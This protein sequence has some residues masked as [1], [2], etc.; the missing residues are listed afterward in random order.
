MSA[1]QK[2][3]TKK[4]IV[5]KNCGTIFN[6]NFCSH[7]GQSAKTHRIDFKHLIH[8]FLHAITHMDV[9]YLH[10]IKDLAIRPGHFIRGYLQGK[11][12]KQGDPALM[13]LIV[14]GLCTWLYKDFHI[15][16][17]TS[18]DIGSLKDGMPMVSMKFFVLSFLAYSL[19][20]SL[21]DYLIFHYKRYNYIELL[22]MNIFACIEIMVF[23]IL[24]IPVW[25]LCNSFG[26]G[27]YMKVA[28][29]ILDLAYLMYVRYQFFEVAADK[30]AQIRIIASG[31][32]I[33]LLFVGTGWKTLLEIFG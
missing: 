16:T 1:S 2:S 22:V 13:L 15:K 19:V 9:M 32:A 26:Y 4:P 31:L 28:V 30:K 12:S 27:D 7:C 24:I 17:L 20:F 25:L 18:V 5:C 29:T 3:N 33:L 10:T 23:F 8:N 14:G 6:G 11:R 21:T